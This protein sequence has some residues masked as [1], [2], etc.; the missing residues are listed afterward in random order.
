MQ[1]G[2]SSEK[3]ARAIE[4]LEPQLEEPEAEMPAA[5]DDAS[6]ANSESSAPRLAIVIKA[7][8]QAVQ[9]QGVARSSSVA[10][11]RA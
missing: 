5:M 6:V 7:M 3:I 1:F 8:Q 9:T 11:R 10:R 4:Q 2:R